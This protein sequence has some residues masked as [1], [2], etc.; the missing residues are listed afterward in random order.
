MP[1]ITHAKLGHGATAKGAHTLGVAATPRH[2][3]RPGSGAA[4]ASRAGIAHEAEHGAMRPGNVKQGSSGS[5]G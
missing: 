2:Q 5:K 1:R 4:A 3:A